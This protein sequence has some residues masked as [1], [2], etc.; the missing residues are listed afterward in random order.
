MMVTL[1][2]LLHD[3]GS[4]V[5][6]DL[7]LELGTER[8]AL[9]GKKAADLVG[10]TWTNI[11]V[12]GERT[13]AYAIGASYVVRVYATRPR[14]D[15][16][17]APIAGVLNETSNGLLLRT[18]DGK[19]FRIASGGPDLTPYRKRRIWI[20]SRWTPR[21]LVVSRIGPF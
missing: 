3:V 2:G 20:I 19:A 5:T 7:Q 13:A 18:D 12:T 9:V 11:C 1:C 16:L 8:V 6:S 17:H 21:G 4:G 14:G 15:G 10:S